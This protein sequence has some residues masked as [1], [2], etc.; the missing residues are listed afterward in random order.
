MHKLQ[1]R[2]KM[3]RVES[4]DLL[5]PLFEKA[6]TD[7]GFSGTETSL[8]DPMPN[9]LNLRDSNVV[10]KRKM[11]V[12]EMGVCSDVREILGGWGDYRFR[13]CKDGVLKGSLFQPCFGSS[14]FSK[15]TEHFVIRKFVRPPLFAF[16]YKLLVTLPTPPQITS[17]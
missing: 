12:V 5:L 7:Q 17:R 14:L 2:G 3:E 15:K 4:F 9:L 16:I 8:V 6:T 1:R 13:F 11:G 10:C